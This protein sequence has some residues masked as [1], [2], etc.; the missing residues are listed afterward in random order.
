MTANNA[1]LQNN[2]ANNSSMMYLDT[3]NGDILAY[4]GSIDYFNTD[5]E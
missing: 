4:V 1:A 2:G 3:T 5:I